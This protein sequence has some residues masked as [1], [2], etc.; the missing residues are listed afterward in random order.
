MRERLHARGRV[1]RGLLAVRSEDVAPRF[2]EK[3]P[4]PPDGVLAAVVDVRPAELLLRPV[5]E[6]LRRLLQVRPGPRRR[7]EIDSRLS[8][9]LLVVDEREVVDQRWEADD[10]ALDRCR[11]AGGRPD[12][13]EA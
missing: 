11:E 4:E 1:E 13:V 9:E 8:E 2:P 7:R 6:L 12:V 5:R 10:L 3:C